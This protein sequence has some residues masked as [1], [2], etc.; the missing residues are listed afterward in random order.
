MLGFNP[1]A[2]CQSKSG[3]KPLNTPQELKEV[4]M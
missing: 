4:Y 1:E 3:F 2:R